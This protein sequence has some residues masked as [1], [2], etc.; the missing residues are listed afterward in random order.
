MTASFRRFAGL[1][2]LLA[3]VGSITYSVTF[4]I[5]VRRSS[6]WAQWASD[7]TLLAGGV[8]A[9]AVLVALYETVRRS[10]PQFALLALVLGL[11][12]CLGAAVHGAYDVAVLSNPIATNPNAPN[13]IDPRGFATFAVSGLALAAFAALGLRS[14]SLSGPLAACGVIGGLLLVVVYFGRLIL[15]DPNANLVKACALL[16][17][18]VLVPAFYVGFARMLLTSAART[19]VLPSQSEKSPELAPTA[20]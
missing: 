19:I 12:G 16:S 14:G 6:H 4:A 13:A 5:Y 11:G 1:C 20:G 9:L 10:E 15:L 17:G 8:V 7:V 2:A 3:A 18:I